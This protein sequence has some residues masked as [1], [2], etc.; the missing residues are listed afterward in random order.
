MRLRVMSALQKE[1]H[2]DSRSAEFLDGE[3]RQRRRQPAWGSLVA[4]LGVDAF[5]GMELLL[6]S[7]KV[8]RREFNHSPSLTASHARTGAYSVSAFSGVV[9]GTRAAD[10]R[11]LALRGQALR[12]PAWARTVYAGRIALMS[13][14]SFLQASPFPPVGAL[15]AVSADDVA[16]LR[17]AA[18]GEPGQTVWPGLFPR[19]PVK[20][21]RLLL[22]ARGEFD[23][24]TLRE[25]AVGR[26]GGD[27]PRAAREARRYDAH[28]AFACALVH[29]DLDA[30]ARAALVAAVL[31]LTPGRRG[32]RSRRKSW[33]I[34]RWA[35]GAGY[36]DGARLPPA[37]AASLPIQ[38]SR[39]RGVLPF[40]SSPCG[41]AAALDCFAAR[42]PH[43]RALL[44]RERA[45]GSWLDYVG[46]AALGHRHFASFQ[47]GCQAS[48]VQ[49]V[50]DAAEH[51]LAHGDAAAKNLVVVGL[52]EAVQGDAYRAGP[53]GDRYEAR[54]GPR[55]LQA[56]AALIEGW[57][58]AGIRDLAAW[59]RKRSPSS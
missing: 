35:A 21:A 45:K 42:W 6:G 22:A 46:I 15:P 33:A 30:D 55:S 52:F 14:A 36:I 19:P 3:Q 26:Y 1:S 18:R 17:A 56:W 47:K 48:W 49:G 28:D 9:A 39:A 32:W 10:A 5:D 51:V 24:A 54:L 20:L 40:V 8:L 43:F 29:P 38:P 50:F 27:R 2:A 59:R 41:P 4:R 37:I 23:A 13:I 11:T 57:T 31:P 53:A 12:G 16:G 7:V 44:A 25:V 34:V 58:G